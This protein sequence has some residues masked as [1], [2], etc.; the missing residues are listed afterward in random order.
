MTRVYKLNIFFLNHPLIKLLSSFLHND[1]ANI[2]NVLSHLTRLSFSALGCNFF[3]QS[4]CLGCGF[5]LDDLK[6]VNKPLV[7]RALFKQGMS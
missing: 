4:I 1:Y 7:E 2:I 6:Y 3:C 5:L